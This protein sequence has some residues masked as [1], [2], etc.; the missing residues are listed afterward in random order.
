MIVLCVTL[1]FFDRWPR[2]EWAGKTGIMKSVS[3][4]I[5]AGFELAAL[6]WPGM[7]GSYS[8]WGISFLL[9]CICF[10]YWIFNFWG[11]IHFSCMFPGFDRGTM[12]L[13]FGELS[14]FSHLL[15]QEEFIASFHDFL[16]IL[17]ALSSRKLLLLF[18]FWPFQCI[19]FVP[20]ASS[21]WWFQSEHELKDLVSSKS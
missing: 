16:Q 11:L 21:R 19:L 3:I 5:W 17:L 8:V 18:V 2:S 9:Y 1:S 15:K 14:C 12:A 10:D 20:V 6:L 13:S 7:G 4:E